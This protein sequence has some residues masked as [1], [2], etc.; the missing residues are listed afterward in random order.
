MKAR[1]VAVGRDNAE[2]VESLLIQKV[3]RIDD[4][5]GIRRILAYGVAVLLDRLNGVVEQFFFPGVKR[6]RGP[7]AVNA[8]VYQVAHAGRFLKDDACVFA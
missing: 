4:E 5:G 1:E 7:I 3:H 2:G 6:G 8:L